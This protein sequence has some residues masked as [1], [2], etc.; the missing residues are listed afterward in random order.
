MAEVFRR[1]GITV[2]LSTEHAS[3]FI[4]NKVAIL[5]ESRLALAVY[6]PSAFCTVT[7]I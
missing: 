1:D 2:T 5:A 4:E 3:Y 7:G 6:R